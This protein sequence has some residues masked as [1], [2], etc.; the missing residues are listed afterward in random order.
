MGQNRLQVGYALLAL[1][2]GIVVKLEL[3]DVNILLTVPYWNIQF[4]NILA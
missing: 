3:G 1:V 4:E 2:L